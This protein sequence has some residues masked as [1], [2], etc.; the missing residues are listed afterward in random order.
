MDE[1]L[2]TRA[3]KVKFRIRGYD[4]GEPKENSKGN[5][6]YSESEKLDLPQGCQSN[7]LNLT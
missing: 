3:L 4:T 1:N 7:P 6:V 2:E 5:E